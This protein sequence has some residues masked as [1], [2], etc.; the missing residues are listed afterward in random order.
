MILIKP[1]LKFFFILG[2]LPILISGC[3]S[4]VPTEESMTLNSPES[5]TEASSDRQLEILDPVQP[6]TRQRAHRQLTLGCNTSTD[7]C[8]ST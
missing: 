3:A 6:S 8:Q 5:P 7:Q 2:L 4:L 1:S